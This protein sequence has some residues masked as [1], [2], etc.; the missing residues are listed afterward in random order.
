VYCYGRNLYRADQNTRRLWV[1]NGTFFVIP[2]FAALTCEMKFIQSKVFAPSK[3]VHLV[4]SHL[5][6]II[7]CNLI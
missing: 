6:D 1:L 2:Y 5:I 4:P 3:L 7:L